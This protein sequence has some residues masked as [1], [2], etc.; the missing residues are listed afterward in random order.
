MTFAQSDHTSDLDTLPRMPVW[1]TSARAET[2]EDVAFLSGAALNHLHLVVGRE[3]VPQALLRDR[4]ALR[5]AETCMVFSGRPERA[6][7]LRDAVH[8]LRPG[9][10]PGPA[11]ETYLA[12]WR[13]V[14]RSV[15]IKALGRALPSLEPGQIATWLDAGQ[16]A[17]V[18]R[19]AR[20]LEVVLTEAP[21]GEVPALILADAALAQALGWDQIV[22]LLAAGLKRA[23]LRKR[24]EDLRIACH[25]ALTFSAIEAVRLAADL[26]RR[27]A[28]LKAVAP[29]LRAKGAAEAVAMFLTRDAVAPAALPL[30]DRAARRLCD[31][32]VDLGALRELTGRDTFRL[33][34]V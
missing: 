5:A 32:L 13:A 1:V 4:L 25:R 23:D 30:P 10:L 33:Y 24:G 12:W 21:R 22:P 14:E 31:R 11:G 3:E 7:E 20:V 6:G 2:L 18:G 8:L 16:G 15:S 19:A 26:A 17:P 34:G 27:A 9:D 28:H 29:K